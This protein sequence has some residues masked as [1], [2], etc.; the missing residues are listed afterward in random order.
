MPESEE[1]V[2]NLINASGFLFQLRVEHAIRTITDR[3]RSVWTIARE[4][5]WVDPTS[6]TEG[7]V[8]LVVEHGAGRMVIECKR[9]QDG[10]WIFLIPDKRDRM[11][12]AKL[13][14]THQQAQRKDLSGWDDFHVA[15]SSPESAFC[16]VRGQGERDVPMLER[17]SGILLRSTEQLANEE[18]AL[19]R[20]SIN[21]T[22]HVYY[23]MIITNAALQVCRFDPCDI[24]PLTGQLPEGEGEFESVPFIRFRKNL[25]TSSSFQRAP[26][27]LKQANT[28]YER[29]VFVINIAELTNILTEWEVGPFDRFT[30]WP[31]IPA[32]QQE[33]GDT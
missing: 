16:T 12:R 30:S 13:L 14:W 7:F 6:G 3:H 4:H 24:D 18:L 11:S 25:S 17:I 20:P 2:R 10:N 15:P 9:V 23:P 29:T 33:S 19:G 28:E 22:P 5:R 8:D 26:S 21:G 31:W 27:D 32:R 1:S